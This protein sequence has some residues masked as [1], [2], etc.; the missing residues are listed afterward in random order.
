M[1]FAGV[2]FHTPPLNDAQIFLLTTN[3]RFFVVCTSVQHMSRN[4]LQAKLCWLLFSFWILV[5]IS[6]VKRLQMQLDG[7]DLWRYG[8]TPYRCNRLICPLARLSGLQCFNISNNGH[9]IN[10]YGVVMIL[11]GNL[12]TGGQ[13]MTFEPIHR[14]L[15]QG[16]WV[17]EIGRAI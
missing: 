14:H 13:P 3:R 16:R 1:I 6:K 7:V 17:S 12:H 2:K 4:I 15:G 8:N 5:N 10:L 9:G 11:M